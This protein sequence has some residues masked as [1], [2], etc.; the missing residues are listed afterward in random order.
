M[1][2]EPL[3]ND[4]QL[5]VAFQMMEGEREGLVRLL[6]AY[7]PRVKCLLQGKFRDVLSEHDVSVALFLAGEKAFKNAHRFDDHKSTLGGWFYTIAFRCAVDLV[8]GDKKDSALP[9]EIDPAAP[10]PEEDCET[11]IVDDPV[12]DDLR[13]CVDEL[14]DKQR[15]IVKAD[16]LAGGEADAASLAEKLGIPKQHVYSYRNKAREALLKRM[17]KRG[18]TADAIRRRR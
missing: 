1:A 16:L 4:G 12:M 17:T 2:E 7:G 8:R 18:H 5:E 6:R 14:G 15:T 13:A 3:S 10:E 9:L 11:I